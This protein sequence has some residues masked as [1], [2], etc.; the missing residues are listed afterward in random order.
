GASE[1][2]PLTYAYGYDPTGH[3]S[4]TRSP[5]G[6]KR[7]NAFDVAGRPLSAHRDMNSA[8]GLSSLSDQANFTTDGDGRILTVQGPLA[9]RSI[10]YDP[11]GHVT[12]IVDQPL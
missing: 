9:T 12:G 11:S 4:T 8:D 3:L 2:S 5:Y 7:I 10:T 6:F 1:P